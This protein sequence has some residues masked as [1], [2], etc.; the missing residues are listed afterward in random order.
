MRHAWRNLI[1]TGAPAVALITASL[2][3]GQADRP[4]SHAK[5]AA[6]VPAAQ[7]AQAARDAD[8]APTF[9]ADVAPIIYEHCVVCHRPGQIAPFPLTSYREVA[10][11]AR[12][13]ALVAEERIMPPWKPREGWNHFQDERRLT[14]AQIDTLV[15]W[16]EAGRPEGD[17]DKTPALPQFKEGWQLG[18]PDI[19]LTMDRAIEVPAEGEDLY[20]HFVFPIEMDTRELYVRGVEVRPG[21]LRVAHHAVGLLD[22]SGKARRL[23]AAYPGPGYLRFGDPGFTPIGMTPGY[24]PGQTP[25]LFKE[26]AAIKITRGTDFVLQVHYHPSGK[27]ERDQTQVGL[28]LTDRPPT[29]KVMGVLMGSEDIDI[30]ANDDT[31]KVYDRFTL[32]V[33]MRAD[34]IWAHM[35]L[36]GKD[37]KVWAELPNGEVKK[38]LWID[39]WDFRWQDTY[40]FD[41][42]ID[43]PAQTVLRAEWRYDNT[44]DNPRNPHH[45]PQRVTHGQN[46]TDEMAGIW[47][48][49]EL[50][51]ELDRVILLGA[52]IGH[53]MQLTKDDPQHHERR[54]ERLMR[55]STPPATGD[56]AD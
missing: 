37:I 28:Y 25:R 2:L 17:R 19:V 13:I 20:M 56:E 6:I 23:D 12:Q 32:P 39:D 14:D 41:E 11:R 10:R 16:A 40:L 33:A 47:L 22:R 46:S 1:V 26:G 34:H 49:G 24:V 53:Y 9:A 38:L 31:Y 54:R 51:N 30:P 45:P 7:P 15:R 50:N 42:P 21:N 3:G 52:N 36:I 48:G 5:S 55:T 4:A 44:A 18:E 35:H 27:V 8:A 43:L 29:R